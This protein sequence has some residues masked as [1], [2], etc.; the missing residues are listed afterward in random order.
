MSVTPAGAHPYALATF[1]GG[2]RTC[3]G[4]HFA[5]LEAKVVA[6]HVLRAYDLELVPGQD[7]AQVGFIT[8]GPA[9]GIRMQVRERA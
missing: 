7:I 8:T 3:I 5:Q 6:A 9:A 1:G 2:P 4:I